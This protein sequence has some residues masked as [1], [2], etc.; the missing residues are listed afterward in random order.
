[1]T[2]PLRLKYSCQSMEESS[3]S[4]MKRNGKL[5]MSTQQIRWISIM[6]DRLFLSFS[7]IIDLPVFFWSAVISFITQCVYR[8]E[9][10]RL[11]GG[12]PSEEYPGD[13][14]DGE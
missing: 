5:M 4:N 12:I 10:G 3:W 1:M 9:V 8:V 6:N 14:A 2:E 13:R 11:L 7:V